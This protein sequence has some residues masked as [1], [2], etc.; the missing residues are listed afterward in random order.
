MGSSPLARGGPCR[1][2]RA[3]CA[4]RLIPARAGRT[5]ITTDSGRR[6]TA[7]PR[8]R[9]ADVGISPGVSASG[10]SSPLARGGPLVLAVW[11]LRSG[12]IPARAGR[13]DLLRLR[14]R[15]R[16]AHPRSR[17]ADTPEPTGQ[18]TPMGSSPLAR[19]G[20]PAARALLRPVGLIPARAGR[21]ASSSAASRSCWAHPRSRGADYMHL[22]SAPTLNGSS[23]LARGGRD[24]RPPG[25]RLDRLIPARAGRT[26]GA[27]RATPRIRA[28]PRS[29]GADLRRKADQAD[30]MGSSPLARG[31]RCRSARRARRRRLIPARAG[32]TGTASMCPC[33]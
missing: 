27:S 5:P 23:P 6:S 9:G 31:G 7:H 21:T 15:G 17:G 14:G 18:T 16:T 4:C 29:R 33:R 20:L 19:G 10:G 28:H 12:L 22:L 1:A 30:E 2:S 8:S 24:P 26:G 11:L 3:G 32:R 13:T 25:G